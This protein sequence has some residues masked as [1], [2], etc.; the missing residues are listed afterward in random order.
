M[1]FPCS[2]DLAVASRVELD[3]ATGLGPRYAMGNA[4]HVANV[5]VVLAVVATACE[6]H[7]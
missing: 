3:L 1:G 2:S 7:S 5:G 6:W 4:M